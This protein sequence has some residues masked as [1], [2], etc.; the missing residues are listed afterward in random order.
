MDMDRVKLEFKHFYAEQKGNTITFGFIYGYDLL[1]P[2][3]VIEL[4]H[5]GS[6]RLDPAFV[7]QWESQE[8]HVAEWITFL[9]RIGLPGGLI[10]HRFGRVPPEKAQSDEERWEYLRQVALGHIKV[11]RCGPKFRDE[12]ER[13][14]KRL[15]L[16]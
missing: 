11:Y 3:L 14:A 8:R 10:A 9:K 13:E 7:E 15:R 6:I 16:L 2:C 4:Q 1:P 5:D 12:L